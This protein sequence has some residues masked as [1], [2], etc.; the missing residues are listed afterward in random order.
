[1]DASITLFCLHTDSSPASK[2]THF[3][4]ASSCRRSFWYFENAVNSKNF[5]PQHNC[6]TTPFPADFYQLTRHVKKQPKQK[7]SSPPTC[8]QVLSEPAQPLTV[9]ERTPLSRRLLTA[10]SSPPPPPLHSA[11]KLQ[12][13]N[14][15]RSSGAQGL[16]TT[17]SHL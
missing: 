2:A 17:N 4:T 12:G 11:N 7:T 8:A 9:A 6:V 13:R 3:T 14:W 16:P 5:S 15:F 10:R 1:M